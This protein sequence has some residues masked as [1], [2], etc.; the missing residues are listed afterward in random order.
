[1]AAQAASPVT[2]SLEHL[3]VAKLSPLT[4]VFWC[5]VH[6][7]SVHTFSKLFTDIE[8]TTHYPTHDPSNGF[9]FFLSK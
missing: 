6:L 9:Q 5:L 3:V 7:A 1:M 2:G 8:N 4:F